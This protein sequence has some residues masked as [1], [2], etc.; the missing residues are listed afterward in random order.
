METLTQGNRR[1]KT[2]GVGNLDEERVQWLMNHLQYRPYFAL[3]GGTYREFSAQYGFSKRE[4]D[5]AIVTLRDRG[6]IRLDEL[7]V[8]LVE[9]PQCSAS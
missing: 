3:D 6:Q 4:L 5:R 7:S 2:C 8:E 1:C 9:E